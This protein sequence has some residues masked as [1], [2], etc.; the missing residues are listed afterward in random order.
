MTT[1]LNALDELLAA[2]KEIYCNNEYNE[3]IFGIL[4]RRLTS[5]K[6]KDRQARNGPVVYFCFGM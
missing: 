5:G 6:K 4:E 1:F 3:K 2:L